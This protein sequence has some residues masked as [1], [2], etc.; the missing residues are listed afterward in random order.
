MNSEGT[1]AQKADNKR[2][3]KTIIK[4]NFVNEI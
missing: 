2:A 1:Q 3:D 4:V